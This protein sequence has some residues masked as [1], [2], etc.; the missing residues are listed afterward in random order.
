MAGRNRHASSTAATRM[1]CNSTTSPIGLLLSGGLDS[2]ILLGRLLGQ[3]RRVQ[4]FYVRC[5]LAWERCELGAAERFLDAVASPDLE[6]LVV[7]DMPLSD[8][9]GD[10]WSVTGRE[11]P[12]ALSP[13]DAVYLPGRNALLVI[14][15]ALWC[16]LHG[17]GQLALA[18]LASN[19]FDD[20]TADFFDDL[21]SAL[22]R[23]TGAGSASPDPS[24]TSPSER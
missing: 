13:D 8:L 15:A 24:R 3:R 11:V 2:C 5:G 4:P 9:Y 22:H 10:H 12:D 7:L 17:I 6:E 16:R 1:N 23:A 20:A 14:K 21:E 18:V 19:P